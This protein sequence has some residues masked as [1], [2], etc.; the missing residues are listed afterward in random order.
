MQQQNRVTFHAALGM[1]TLLF[2]SSAKAS[3]SLH[4][5]ES[6]PSLAEI[7][8][9][10][11]RTKSSTSR[12]LPIRAQNVATWHTKAQTMKMTAN[13]RPGRRKNTWTTTDLKVSRFHMPSEKNAPLKLRKTEEFCMMWF[14]IAWPILGRN[15]EAVWRGRFGHSQDIWYCF[16]MKVRR[17]AA[18]EY[19]LCSTNK[20]NGMFGGS[21]AFDGEQRTDLRYVY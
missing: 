8:R 13:S 20:L 6:S 9:A 14:K 3:N 4:F 17:S 5:L 11:I 15:R 12:M 1:I 7:S 19:A 16:S 21:T 18:N 10:M 2:R